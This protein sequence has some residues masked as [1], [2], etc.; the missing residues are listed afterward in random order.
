MKAYRFRL[1]SVARVRVLEER[2]ARDRFIAAQREL[3][4]AEAMERQASS[5]LRALEAPAG[6][7]TVADLVWLGEQADRWSESVRACRER[8]GEARAGCT[9]ARQAWNEAAKRA[10]VLERLDAEGRDQ[11]RRDVLRDEVAELDD[12]A[13]IR[14]GRVGAGR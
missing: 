10:S 5:A 3:R 9:A 13:Q 8:V 4:Q 1:A 2:V 14:H 12:L 7:T 11:W 6:S